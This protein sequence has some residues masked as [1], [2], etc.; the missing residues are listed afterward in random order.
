MNVT[1][2]THFS[3]RG[4][5]QVSSGFGIPVRSGI[6][7]LFDFEYLLQFDKVY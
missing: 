2:A 4:G 7:K 3:L 5:T 6:D 1:L